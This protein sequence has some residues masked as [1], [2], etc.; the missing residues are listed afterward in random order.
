MSDDDQIEIP[1][2]F[3]ALYLPPGR[4]KPTLPRAELA[5]RYE[6]CEDM[7]QMLI[8][9][10]RTMEFSLGITEADVLQ[11]VGQGLRGEGAVVSPDEAT[12]VVTRLA[13]LLDC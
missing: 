11:R 5:A 4:L 2:S 7:A 12:W 3:I 6:L 8:D 9:T 1:A 13:E 10:A